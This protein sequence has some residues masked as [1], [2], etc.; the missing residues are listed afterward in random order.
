MYAHISSYNDI[1]S[2]LLNTITLLQKHEGR[3]IQYVFAWQIINMIDML[4]IW[5]RLYYI[6]MYQNHTGYTKLLYPRYGWIPRLFYIIPVRRHVW[7]WTS[8]R[9]RDIEDS[10]WVRVQDKDIF[11]RR[12]TRRPSDE[13]ARSA[14]NEPGKDI[15]ILH[16]EAWRILYLSIWGWLRSLINIT[17]HSKCHFR[18]NYIFRYRT[19]SQRFIV[20]A[21]FSPILIIN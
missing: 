1:F 19:S 9:E 4:C 7:R 18:L 20:H 14:R 17:F 2:D 3:Q 6:P 21:S 8:E 5:S 11:S 15:L 16:E 12:V 13:E 10:S